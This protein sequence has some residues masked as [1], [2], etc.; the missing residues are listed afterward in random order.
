MTAANRTTQLGRTGPR[1]FPIAL[2]CMSMS[3]A[4]GPSDESESIATLREAIDR[5]VTLIDT[6]DFYASGHNELLIRRAIEGQRDKVRLSVKFGAMRGPDGVPVGFDGRP[7]AVKNFVTYSLQ[8]LGVDHIDVYRPA[9]LDPHV[10]IE[11]TV[12]AIAELVK[13]GYVRNIGLSEV[14]AETIRRA[15]KVHP[16]SD[17]QI[18]YSLI[19]REPEKT[20]FPTLAELGMSATLYG[21]LSRGLLTGAKVEGARLHYPRFS[22]EAGQRNAAA[23]A[24]FHA[25]A[26]E[27]G[28]TPAQLSV[29]WVLAKQ[30]AF[31]PVVGARTR[32]QLLD[33]L[34]ALEKPLS[35]GDV[36]AVEAILPKEAIAGSRYPE[37]QMKVL[38]SER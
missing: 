26:A 34:G 25:Y 7:A 27:R 23:V 1:V 19:T 31:V 17:L 12:G 15:A 30:P 29:A 38:D 6:A 32:K 18:E 16:L 14:G 3:G 22:G 21:V 20:L 35:S 37:Q 24:R 28:M 2:G 33:V 4:Y 11:D 10:P 9:R 13:G 36:A 5:G 8:R